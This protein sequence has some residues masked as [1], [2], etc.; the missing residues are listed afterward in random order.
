MGVPSTLT[1]NPTTLVPRDQGGSVP[2]RQR[3][4]GR[5]SDPGLWLHPEREQQA[6]LRPLDG[7]KF[8]QP[9]PWGSLGALPA[10][11]SRVGARPHGLVC[12]AFAAGRAPSTP[13]PDP[14]GAAFS[15][16]TCRVA[17]WSP[18]LKAASAPPPHPP[19]P[20]TAAR[21]CLPF[22]R[23]PAVPHTPP[24]KRTKRTAP[25]T[26]ARARRSA[27]RPLNLQAA[28]SQLF[29]TPTR[30]LA[31]TAAATTAAPSEPATHPKPQKQTEP[32]KGALSLPAPPPTPAP[33]SSRSG[34]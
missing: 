25:T 30:P 23:A 17:L 10:R 6:E 31:A 29:P 20:Q 24:G 21:L 14:T 8:R 12:A 4:P 33:P 34:D 7:P 2:G 13:G 3:T 1:P 19:V 27:D 16:P 18:E 9:A 5:L 15:L 11:D 26:A 32:R 28:A 22:S